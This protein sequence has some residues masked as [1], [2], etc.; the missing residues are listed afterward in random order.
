MLRAVSVLSSNVLAFRLSFAHRSPQGC[1]IYIYIINRE[2]SYNYNFDF[3]SNE[4]SVFWFAGRSRPCALSG[5]WAEGIIADYRCLLPDK[6]QQGYQIRVFDLID[7]IE[8]SKVGL[9]GQFPH[10]AAR[11]KMDAL[12][13]DLEME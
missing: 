9:G 12:Q 6:S 13:G 8:Q 10:L 3:R 7:L 4:R 11:L 2:Q 1:Y 5:K